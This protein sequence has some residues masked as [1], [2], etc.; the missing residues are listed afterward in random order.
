MEKNYYYG[1]PEGDEELFLDILSK[2]TD[3]NSFRTSSIPLTE[4]WLSRNKELNQTL[5]NK[6]NPAIDFD[7]TKKCFEYPVY[8][9][10]NYNGQEQRIGQPSMTDLM[11][12]TE[13]Y[14]IAVE[15][16]FTENLYETIFKWLPKDSKKT[17][18]YDVLQSWYKYIKPYCNYKDKDVNEIEKK[19]V[20]QFLHRTAS[21]CYCSSKNSTMPVVL[22][23]LFYNKTDEKS[24]K[25]QE[26]VAVKLNEFASLLGFDSKKIKLIIELTPITNFNEVR[27]YYNGIKSDIFSVMKRKP[28]YKFE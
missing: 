15:G 24:K 19:V 18:K 6:I 28:I 12:F 21:A 26:E 4:F 20:Y 27:E 8:A 3:V 25:H 23:Q 2:N 11:L 16:K 10:K 17:D 22:Y 9:T 1:T 5:L 14:T 7:S 13:N